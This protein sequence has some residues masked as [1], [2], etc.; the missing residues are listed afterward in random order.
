MKLIGRVSGIVACREAP[1]E[2]IPDRPPPMQDVVNLIRETYQF[3]SFPVL[4]PGINLNGPFSFG[5]GRFIHQQQTFAIALLIMMAEGGIVSTTS[6]EDS[7]LVIDHLASLLD[8]NFG[9][10]LKQAKLKRSYLSTM[11]VEFDNAFSTYI[12]KIDKMERLINGL[13]PEG[14]EERLFKNFGFGR[15]E[16]TGPVTNQIALVENADFVIERRIGHSFSSNRFY[17][18]APMRTRDH[19]RALEQIEAIAREDLV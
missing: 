5:G 3:V 9:Y 4:Q 8:Q 14:A 17:C 6:T 15:E 13:L 10:R 7:D 11:V 1:E 18:V 12:R 16:L 2:Y 19:I